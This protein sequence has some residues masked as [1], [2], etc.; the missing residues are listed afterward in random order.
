FTGETP[1][2]VVYQHVQDIPV[3]PSEVAEAS[4]PELDGLVMRSL[5][6]EP[7][8]RFQT[9]E[10]MRGLI[11]YALQMIYEQ[12]VHTGTWNTGTVVMPEGPRTPAAGTAGTT[13]LPHP[14]AAST[15]AIPQPV[16]PAG[17]GKGDDGGFEGHGNKGSGRGKLLLFAVLAVIAV[18]A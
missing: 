6:K 10:E 4:P 12:G 2:S 3:P 5:A 1:L 18:A 13:A 7:D 15:A 11:Q 17:Y 8:D 14:N 16:L 9:A